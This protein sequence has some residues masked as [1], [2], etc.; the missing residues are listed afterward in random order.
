MNP[1]SLV[2]AYAK[3]SGIHKADASTSAQQNFLDENTVTGLPFPIPQNDCSIRGGEKDVSD[4]CKRIL[5][6]NA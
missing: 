6:N 2:S 5:G 4:V 3:R 1:Y